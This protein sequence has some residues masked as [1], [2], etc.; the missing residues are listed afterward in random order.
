MYTIFRNVYQLFNSTFIG[1]E[2]DILSET[3]LTAELIE[4]L[5]RFYPFDHNVLKSTV[6]K[7]DK[8]IRYENRILSVEKIVGDLYKQT[9]LRYN[10]E[11]EDTVVSNKMTE[12]SAEK[13]SFFEE[14]KVKEINLRRAGK[15][16][17][18]LDNLM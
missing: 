9:M 12:F 13:T 5:V 8:E 2:K 6:Q 14:D 1:L 7:A 10:K 4:K 18:R 16:R 3:K 17:W 15:F 11:K